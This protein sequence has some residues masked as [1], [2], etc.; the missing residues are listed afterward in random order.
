MNTQA[1]LAQCFRALHVPGIPL[2][3][4]NIRDAE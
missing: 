4:F 2:V 1:D 3:L